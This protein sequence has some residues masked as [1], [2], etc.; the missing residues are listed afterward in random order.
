MW[1]QENISSVLLSHIV[2]WHHKLIVWY[3]GADKPMVDLYFCQLFKKSCG[4]S[5]NSSYMRQCGLVN[6]YGVYIF[7][8]FFAVVRNDFHSNHFLRNFFYSYKFV[9]HSNQFLRN[10]FYSYKFVF[11]YNQFLRNFFYSYKFSMWFMLHI[12]VTSHERDGIS[13][14]WLLSSLFNS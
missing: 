9:F 11:H 1:I 5:I 14:Y 8:F 2:E 4:I 3:K 13:N 6:W 7:F 10:F 12:T